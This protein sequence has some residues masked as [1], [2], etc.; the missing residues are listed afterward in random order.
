M[1]FLSS[2]PIV[3]LFAKFE[4]SNVKFIKLQP[5]FL[6]TLTVLVAGL[7][8]CQLFRKKA[9]PATTK[10]I[11]EIYNNGTQ[12]LLEGSFR[13]VAN[14]GLP[15]YRPGAKTFWEHFVRIP[16]TYQFQELFLKNDLN[17]KDLVLNVLCSPWLEDALGNAPAGDPDELRQKRNC[18]FADNDAEISQKNKN[19]ISPFLAVLLFL[20]EQIGEQSSEQLSKLLKADVPT[21]IKEMIRL[22]EK[23]WTEFRTLDI[24]SFLSTLRQGSNLTPRCS[25]WSAVKGSQFVA[26]V[27]LR[28]LAGQSLLVT[29]ERSCSAELNTAFREDLEESIA[30]LN[31]KKAPQTFAA[32][33]SNTLT[34]SQTSQFPTPGLL[35]FCSKAGDRDACYARPLAF[36]D[37]KALT[38]KQA[39]GQS[40]LRLT[41]E[42]ALPM[43]RTARLVSSKLIAFEEPTWLSSETGVSP[44]PGE[45]GFDL[46]DSDVQLGEPVWNQCTPWF[47]DVSSGQP[48]TDGSQIRQIRFCK[49]YPDP[50]RRNPVAVMLD[51]AKQLYSD[52]TSD[53]G[54]KILGMVRES[55]L[56]QDKWAQFRVLPASDFLFLAQSP[57]RTICDPWKKLAPQG[58]AAI[59]NTDLAG[60][61]ILW[62]WSR[63]CS[64]FL[65]NEQTRIRKELQFADASAPEWSSGQVIDKSLPQ[66]ASADNLQSVDSKLQDKKTKSEKK[67]EKKKGKKKKKEKSLSLDSELASTLTS[68]QEPIEE[69]EPDMFG[70]GNSTEQ[71]QGLF[72]YREYSQFPTEGLAEYCRRDVFACLGVRVD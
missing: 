34:W 26:G 52:L 3:L 67:K 24:P 72:L 43:I 27:D 50:N 65:T 56:G 21:E 48:W 41:A 45:P 5:V 53:P 22:N 60:A 20:R 54:N 36:E 7:T 10:G 61:K 63:R 32:L 28:N 31:I 49:L 12:M 23:G 47:D 38:V 33:E 58:L 25:L 68:T 19:L 2:N 6:V 15:E 51:Q 55:F 44:L 66:V 30:A 13:S 9:G 18:R 62:S 57:S 35:E 69:H 59:A 8:S 17:K 70:S 16:E 14:W 39:L 71:A 37:T 11:G 40:A 1:S 29:Y 64:V 46:S 4:E 42:T